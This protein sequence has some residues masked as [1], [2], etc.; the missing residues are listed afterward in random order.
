MADAATHDEEMKHFMGAKVWIFGV[1]NRQ[2][3][4]ID[5]A[6]DGIN[7]TSRKQPQKSCGG[8]GIPKGAKDGNANPAHG[9][10][11]EG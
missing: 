7:N 1:K 4:G 10:I 9:N 3:K 6:A 8:Q 2:F 5:H 11:N